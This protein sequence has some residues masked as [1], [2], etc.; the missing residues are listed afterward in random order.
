MD[1]EENT[2]EIS[3]FSC[4]LKNPRHPDIDKPQCGLNNNDIFFFEN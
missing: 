2:E 3:E 1:V 4:K